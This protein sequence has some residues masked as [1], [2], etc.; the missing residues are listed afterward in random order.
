MIYKN[1]R[2][3]KEVVSISKRFAK[4]IKMLIKKLLRV[5]LFK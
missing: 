1:N 2:S 3:K 5:D 4:K